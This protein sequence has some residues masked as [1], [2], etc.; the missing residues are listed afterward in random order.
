MMY[1]GVMPDWMGWMMLGSYLFWAALV[2][3]GVILVIR[4]WRPAQDRDA[5]RA[6]LAERFARGEIGEEELRTRLAALRSA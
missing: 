2:A 6:I 3:L 4:V 5:A 1:P